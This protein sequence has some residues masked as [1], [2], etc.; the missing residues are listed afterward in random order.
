LVW[1]GLV[2]FGLVWFGLVWFGLVWFGLVRK[3][4][5][6]YLRYKKIKYLLFLIIILLNNE[7]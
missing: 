3:N 2:W 6:F 1:F 4:E 5:N 7:F